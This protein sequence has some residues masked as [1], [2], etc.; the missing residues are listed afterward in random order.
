MRKVFWD[1]PYQHTLNTQVVEVNDCEVLFAETIVFSFSGGQ[2][3]DKAF[4]NGIEVIGSRMEGNL[5]YYTLPEGHDLEPN[6]NVEM[7]IDWPRRHNLMR[8]HF[9]AEL[10]LEIVTR[11]YGFEKVG[12]HIS[13]SKARID[14]ISD[15]NISSIFEEVLAEYNEIINSDKPIEKGFTDV[16]TQRRYWK[17]DGF[18]EVPCGG[19]HVKSTA[20]VGCV[21]LKRSH[22]G[23]SIE[24][25]E[26]RLA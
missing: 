9:A 8:L 11:K 10:I 7:T 13:E 23:K 12:A 17:I 18:A 24:R 19:T 3:S 5:I 4:I 21:A 20:E 6:E 1:D 25:I 26:I 22:P 15:N 14:F 16:E 2:E